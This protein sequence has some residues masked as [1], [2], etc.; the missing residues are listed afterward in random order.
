M[1][2]EHATNPREC[3]VTD[4]DAQAERVI[5]DLLAAFPLAFSAEPRHIK[6]LAIGTRQQ[7]FAR[8][9][10]SHSHRSVGDA[11]WRYTKCAAYLRTII[12]GAVRVD[13]D[14]ATSGNVTAMEAAHAAE[15]IMTCL[16]VGA[17]KPEDAIKPDAPAKADMSQSLE[18]RDASQP[19]PRRFGLADLRRAAAARR[20]PTST[21]H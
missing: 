18:N 20:T 16:P 12:E 13:L 11:L 4:R 5:R 6:P 2:I 17:G 1:S 21:A 15:R 3:L 14:G 10:F 9:T 8:C 7:I 19:G